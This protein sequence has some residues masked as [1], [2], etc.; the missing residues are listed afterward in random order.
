MTP[1]PA[2]PDALW[3][4]PKPATWGS[5]L[6]STVEPKSGSAIKYVRA[7]LSPHVDAVKAIEWMNRHVVFPHEIKMTVYGALNAHASPA[8]AEL[9]EVLRCLLKNYDDEAQV[10]YC[11]PDKGCLQCTAGTTPN[12]LNT[13]PCEYH[14]A[15][16]VL[17]KHAATKAGG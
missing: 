16:S 8:V 3:I 15:K 4:E 2:M 14:M 17:T 1:K 7:D 10:I 11:S 6:F 13:G 12:H 9:V 5:M